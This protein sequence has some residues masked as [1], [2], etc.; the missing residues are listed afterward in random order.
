MRM[1]IH[2]L[3]VLSGARVVVDDINQL[4]ATSRQ[5]AEYAA[6]LRA[7]AESITANIVEGFGR[8]EGPDRDRFLRYSRGSAEETCERL[9]SG[10]SARRVAKQDY[11]RNHNRITVIVRMLDGL[12]DQSATSRT[13]RKKPKLSKRRRRSKKRV[14]T[15][16]RKAQ[17]AGMNRRS[18]QWL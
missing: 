10:Y 16:G 4:L 8:G 13:R 1:P 6:Q 7:A 5:P 2:G 12:I 14:S 17:K 15:E 9:R 18:K 3:R 11:W